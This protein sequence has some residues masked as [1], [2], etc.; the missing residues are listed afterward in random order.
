[1]NPESAYLSHY[2]KS[3]RSSQQSE[4]SD[5]ASQRSKNPNEPSVFTKFS[6]AKSY[7][8]QIVTKLPPS[9]GTTPKKTFAEDY[10]VRQSQ[11]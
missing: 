2:M 3:V 10:R 1:M 6:D 9:E 11:Q 8:N 4:R 7:L 5:T